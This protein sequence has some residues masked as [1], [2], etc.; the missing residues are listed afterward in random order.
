MGQY[1]LK[2]ESLHFPSL[3]SGSI[4]Y[5]KWL[6]PYFLLTRWAVPSPCPLI[7]CWLAGICEG[8]SSHRKNMLTGQMGNC[9]KCATYSRHGQLTVCLRSVSLFFLIQKLVTKALPFWLPPFIWKNTRPG[10]VIGENDPLNS[11][12]TEWLQ[13]SAQQDSMQYVRMLGMFSTHFVCHVL[14]HFF[15]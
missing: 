8:E 3:D 4:N 9:A 5:F 13:N 6:F 15:V 12:T 11:V 1:N 7:N 14:R 10:V 2:E